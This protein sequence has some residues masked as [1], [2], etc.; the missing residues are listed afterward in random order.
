MNKR[1]LVNVTAVILCWLLFV[2]ID[3]LKKGNLFSMEGIL[4]YN[5][6]SGTII[7]ML[8]TLPLFRVFEKTSKFT[9]TKRALILVLLGIAVGVLKNF[10]TW[11]TVFIIGISSGL[12]SASWVSFKKFF[13]F[14]TLFYYMEAIIISWVLLII[15]FMLELYKQYKQKSIETAQLESQLANAQLESLRMQLQPHFLFNAHNTVS[16][17]IRTEKYEQATEM[18]SKISDLLRNSLKSE[19]RQLVPLHQEV[20]LIKSYLEIEEVRFEDHLKINLQFDPN[21]LD[22]MVPNLLLQPLVENAFKH[23]IS[24]NLGEAQLTLSSSLN[25]DKLVLTVANTGPSLPPDF[26]IEKATGIGLNNV[27][28]RLSKLYSADR[29]SFEIKNSNTGVKVEIQIPI[30]N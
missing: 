26:R 12:Y 6:I 25:R 17:L 9:L 10:L 1:S 30:D 18:I 22:I 23:G 11:L 19:E 16:M 7:W 5:Y 29:H 2:V 13:S 3:T 27:I 14:I 8:I 15:F 24:K 21:T 28:Q 20:T 4:S